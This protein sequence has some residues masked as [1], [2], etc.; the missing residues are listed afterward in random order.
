MEMPIIIDQ[1]SD[2]VVISGCSFDKI[3]GTEGAIFVRMGH[4]PSGRTLVYNNTFTRCSGLVKSSV[5]YLKQ[6][7]D[8]TA[9]ANAT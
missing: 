7:F 8:K 2:N 1:Q 5:L 9:S 4:E 3:S 6:Y